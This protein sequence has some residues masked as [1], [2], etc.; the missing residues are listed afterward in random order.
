MSP[1]VADFSSLKPL[2]GINTEKVEKARSIPSAISSSAA[3]VG[4]VSNTAASTGTHE[5]GAILPFKEA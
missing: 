2:I 4:Y 5:G 1:T 3:A